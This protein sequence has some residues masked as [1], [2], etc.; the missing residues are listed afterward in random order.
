M[1][2]AAA[3]EPHRLCVHAADQR[4]QPVALCS[5]S[6]RH[7]SVA[8]RPGHRGRAADQII[9]GP[10]RLAWLAALEEQGGMAT[11]L[12]A[13]AYKRNFTKEMQRTE[14]MMKRAQIEP[15]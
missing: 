15:M 2:K 6:G 11:P 4:L 12:D 5:G 3:R 1:R 10:G 8:E 13:D 7:R 14:A 9:L